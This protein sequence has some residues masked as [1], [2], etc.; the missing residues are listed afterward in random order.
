VVESK[1]GGLP[2]NGRE[3]VPPS[4][5]KESLQREIGGDI[6]GRT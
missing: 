6:R 1:K 2:M 3:R 4:I 5:S